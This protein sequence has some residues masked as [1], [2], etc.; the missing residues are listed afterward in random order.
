MNSFL[1]ISRRAGQ[2]FLVRF[3][4]SSLGPAK[5]A[6]HLTL[7]LGQTKRRVTLPLTL[8]N[9]S[10]IVSVFDLLTCLDGCNTGTAKYAPA[11]QSDRNNPVRGRSQIGGESARLI[12]FLSLPCR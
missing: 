2:K 5:K 9:R 7:L 11:G 6:S 10:L 12:A 1:F 8:A 4:Q 3:V